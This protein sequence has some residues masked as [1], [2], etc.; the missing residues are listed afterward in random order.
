[1]RTFPTWV[2]LTSLSL[3]AQEGKPGSK[4]EAAA[5]EALQRTA[6]GKPDMSGVWQATGTPAGLDVGRPGG[7]VGGG[8]V[9][10]QPWAEAK[11]KEY[12]AALGK[13]DPAT[14]CLPPGPPRINYIFPITLVQNRSDVRLSKRKALL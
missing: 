14:R 11:Y 12:N 10:Y 9:P 3:F 13:D 4:L 8:Q 7:I 5:P 6:D 1:M 2:G